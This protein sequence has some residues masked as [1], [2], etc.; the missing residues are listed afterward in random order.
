MNLIIPAARHRLS[1]S[2]PLFSSSCFS[3]ASFRKVL[4]QGLH[5]SE[6]QDRAKCV[7]YSVVLE[8]REVPAVFAAFSLPFT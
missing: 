8:G 6:R 7:T 1:G 2:Y 4:A 5:G 3:L